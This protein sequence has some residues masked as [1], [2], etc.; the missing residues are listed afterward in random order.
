MR[1]VAVHTLQGNRKER[2]DRASI[3]VLRIGEA[4]DSTKAAS[5]DPKVSMK[6]VKRYYYQNDEKE[7]YVVAEENW[8][9]ERIFSSYLL[10]TS[11]AQ[12]T[13]DALR[14]GE[15]PFDDLFQPYHEEQ[16][17]NE[18]AE[19]KKHKR[20]SDGDDEMEYVDKPVRNARR[21]RS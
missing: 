21:A 12:D 15:A 3:P 1:A 16:Q 18:D 5:I 11:T 8:K 17:S 13:L 19:P 14:L 6:I 10:S 20:D 9:E 2:S 4:D 7:S